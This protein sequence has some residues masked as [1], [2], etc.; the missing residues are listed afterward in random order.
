MSQHAI[1]V[2]LHG[3]LAALARS[4][5][6]VHRFVLE[7]RASVKDVVES[8]G[9]PHT[10]V[11]ALCVGGRQVGFG[12]AVA[13]GEVLDVHPFTPPVDIA[14]SSWFAD[15]APRRPAFLADANVGR[16]ARELRLLGFDTLYDR[17]MHDAE[18]AER[19]ETERRIVLSRDRMLLKRSRVQWGR[20]VRASAPAEQLVEV[21]V[22]YGLAPPYALFSRCA[23]CNA[24][25]RPVAK[26]E[27]L[28]LLE[29]KTKRY[30]EDFTQCPACGRVYWAGSHGEGMRARLAATA[31]RV[32]AALAH[33]RRDIESTPCSRFTNS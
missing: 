3:E 19:A 30:Y 26:A 14:S 27:V 7:R 24:V 15:W 2:R 8:L 29:P 28:H 13:A 33:A 4:K 23:A 6:A 5:R 31:R 11:G 25:L 16:L 32:S 9:P 21:L 18:I 20:L 17:S 1:T 12:H 10:E 22:F